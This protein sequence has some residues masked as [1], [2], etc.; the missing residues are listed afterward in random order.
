VIIAGWFHCFLVIYDHKEKANAKWTSRQIA[1]QL[2]TVG[3]G[4]N[5]PH[6]CHAVA[7]SPTISFTSFC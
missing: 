1:T 7:A 5:Q 4:R 3:P 6:P 2:D